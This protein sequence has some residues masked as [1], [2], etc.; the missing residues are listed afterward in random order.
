MYPEKICLASKTI[1]IAENNLYLELTNRMCYYDE[2]NLNDV[3]L[4]YKDV[5]EMALECA[6]SLINMPV[7]AAYKK[8]EGQ[9]DPPARRL[10]K[11]ESHLRF[12]SHSIWMPA[13]RSCPERRPPA[14][15]LKI[16]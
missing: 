11:P 14:H 9:D 7:Q 1:D 10:R 8:I 12:S 2:R 15:R 5:E 16:R 6:K 4:P 3:L 13:D